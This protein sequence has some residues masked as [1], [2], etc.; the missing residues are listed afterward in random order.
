MATHNEGGQ[1]QSR[2]HQ[3]ALNFQAPLQPL[4]QAQPPAFQPNVDFSADAMQSLHS[5]PMELWERPAPS[6]PLQAMDWDPAAVEQ[7][8]HVGGLPQ[9]L[10]HYG[11]LATYP[12]PDPH[13]E[14]MASLAGG[15]PYSLVSHSPD[16]ELEPVNYANYTSWHGVEH[17]PTGRPPA[18]SGDLPPTY[19]DLPPAYPATA[20]YPSAFPSAFPAAHPPAAAAS[21]PSDLVHYSVPT[22][23]STFNSFPSSPHPLASSTAT[24]NPVF[25]SS[26]TPNVA[27]S[28]GL[29]LQVSDWQM[30]D[31]P[32]PVGS[33]GRSHGPRNNRPNAIQQRFPA[34]P[35]PQQIASQPQYV[36]SD[37]QRVGELGARPIGD[38]AA[39][40]NRPIRLMEKCK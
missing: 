35:A 22:T 21:G 39:V 3:H 10:L 9:D 4:T 18:V 36:A 20:T 5:M 11:G 32:P 34:L 30:A 16:L 19:P 28:S 40:S 15:S 25:S 38:F 1:Q 37:V 17:V 33:H 31:A 7:H 6:P 29:P 23:S 13:G 27:P 14:F 12:Q 24:F 26:P 8:V 2:P